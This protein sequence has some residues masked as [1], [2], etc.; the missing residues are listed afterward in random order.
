MQVDNS[1]LAEPDGKARPTPRSR[2]ICKHAGAHYHIWVFADNGTEYP[3]RLSRMAKRYRSRQQA[4]R[5]LALRP[6]GG[7]VLKC[8]P[9]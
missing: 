9:R 4:H 6:F 8:K 5:D 3:T 7:V 1:T 2:M